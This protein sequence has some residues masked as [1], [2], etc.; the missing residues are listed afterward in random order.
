M[1]GPDFL[2]FLSFSGKVPRLE[3]ELLN[4]WLRSLK[5]Q[6][7]DSTVTVLTDPESSQILKGL[8]FETFI[9]PVRRETL[10]LD[11]AK[12]LL[13]FL[14][15]RAEG[16]KVVLMDYDMLLLKPLGILELDVDC[17][18]TLRHLAK[19]QP[20][21][22]GLVYFRKSRAT[23]ALQE[24][25]IGA[26]EVFAEKDRQWWG[27]QLSVSAILSEMI[28]PL[29]E[30]IH[31]CGDLKVALVGTELYNFTPFDLDVSRPTLLK[32]LILQVPII[33]WLGNSVNEKFILHFKGPRKHLQFQV[34]YELE[35][36]TIYRDHL[37]AVF[38]QIVHDL[39]VYG[40]EW[41]D[42]ET[43][44]ASYP[45]H[46]LN[47]LA[48]LTFLNLNYFISSKGSSSW[49]DE[50]LKFLETSNDF[51]YKLLGNKDYQQEQV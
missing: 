40:I 38:T 39:N 9:T 42:Y 44:K 17:C 2:T 45:R 30:G 36:G 18:Y 27:D 32:H 11:R 41:F 48:V 4:T 6:H 20:I 25:V 3:F 24:K 46:L 47:D 34:F 14:K 50:V 8:G 31:S 26:Y 43:T 21:N 7:P 1:Y 12:G 10:L 15:T 5:K 51:R 19:R 16:T 35:H 28:S 49:G 37:K 29:R 23:I 22:G 13:S 33:E